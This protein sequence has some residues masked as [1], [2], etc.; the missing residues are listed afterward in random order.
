MIGWFDD[1]QGFAQSVLTLVLVAA[2]VYYA[3][4][5]RKATRSA[6]AAVEAA[7][8]ANEHS[9]ALVREAVKARLDQQAPS[10]SVD[11]RTNWEPVQPRDEAPRPL[12]A[13]R[14]SPWRLFVRIDVS[15]SGDSHARVTASK[16]SIGY[17]WT[18]DVGVEHV[19]H[20][21]AP[22]S[23]FLLVFDHCSDAAE[24]LRL[25]ASDIEYTLALASVLGGTV[26]TFR[27]TGQAPFK[28]Q[29]I[30]KDSAAELAPTTCST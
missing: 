24:A 13:Y 18:R 16:P 22:T 9:E 11:L 20:P 10:A 19:L 30:L 1:H 3:A 21:G 5:T 12:D 25:G 15:V 2:T 14:D 17:H 26:D 27:W 28:T 6:A 29:A 4:Q 7:Q 8:A 23:T